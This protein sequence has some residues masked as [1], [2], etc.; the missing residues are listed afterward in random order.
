MRAC[1]HVCMTT[2]A[3]WMGALAQ[4]HTYHSTPETMTH[5][6]GDRVTSGLSVA[7]SSSPIIQTEGM[8]GISEHVVVERYPFV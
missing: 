1:I 2:L 4:Y 6:T 7:S 5:G 3:E 8:A